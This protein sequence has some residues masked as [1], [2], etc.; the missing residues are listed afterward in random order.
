MIGHFWSFF[1]P[2]ILALDELGAVVV[3]GNQIVQGAH[4]LRERFGE[5]LKLQIFS[6]L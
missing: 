2:C 3:L 1:N 6:H 5:V 4:D